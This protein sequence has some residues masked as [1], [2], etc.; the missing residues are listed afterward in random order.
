MI[1]NL[2]VNFEIHSGCIITESL[3]KAL[4]E[5]SFPLDGYNISFKNHAE[6]IFIFIGNVNDISVPKIPLNALNNNR[7]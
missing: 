1:K 3:L 2:N 6:D 5:R 4:N 7:L